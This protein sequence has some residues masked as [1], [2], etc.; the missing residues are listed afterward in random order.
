MPLCALRL[1]V[2]CPNAEYHGCGR[3]EQAVGSF[4]DRNKFNKNYLVLL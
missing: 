1:G 2:I 3:V 4:I